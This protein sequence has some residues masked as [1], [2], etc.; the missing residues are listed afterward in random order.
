MTNGPSNTSFNSPW[1]AA[2]APDRFT[3]EFSKIGI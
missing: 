1:F 2:L 3:I